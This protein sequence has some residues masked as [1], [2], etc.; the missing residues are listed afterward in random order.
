[1][2]PVN[3]WKIAGYG[4][5]PWPK[6]GLDWA[7]MFERMIP[8]TS[9]YGNVQGDEMEEGTQI[10]QHGKKEWIPGT[11]EYNAYCK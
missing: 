9:H 2:R 5:A 1:M 10:W 4:K 3:G 8:P 11:K 6:P 7:V